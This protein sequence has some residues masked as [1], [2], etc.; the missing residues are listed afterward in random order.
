MKTEIKSYEGKINTNFHNDKIP[1]EGS[2]CICLS[3]VLIDYVFKMGKSYYTHVS[4]EE[5][6]YVFKKEEVTRNV[7]I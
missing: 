7:F 2:H 3:V 5:C 6:K 1:K 4:L